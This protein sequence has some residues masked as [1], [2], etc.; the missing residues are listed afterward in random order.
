MAARPS[1]NDAR[2]LARARAE[3][4][5]WEASKPGYVSHVADFLLDS[6]EKVSARLVPPHLQSA[7]EK[8]VISALL[9][10]QRVAKNSVDP[11]E[12]AAR[13]AAQKAKGLEGMDLAAQDYWSQNLALAAVEGGAAGVAGLA[14]LALDVPAMLGLALRAIHQIGACYGYDVSDELEREYAL[15]VLR[16]GSSGNVQ[17]KIK[18]SVSLNELEAILRAR[19]WKKLSDGEARRQINRMSLLLAL[20][21]FAKTLALQLTKRK[22]LQMIPVTGAL[23]GAGFNAQFL[24]DVSRSAYM[25]YRRRKLADLEEPD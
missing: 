9:E 7:L 22:A 25:S 3:I 23:V 2:Y 20:R 4:R 15:Q 18:F 10:L 16:L 1:K 17:V 13:V 12:A 11:A 24:N 14:G 6:V 5:E 8:N 19:S 21:Q